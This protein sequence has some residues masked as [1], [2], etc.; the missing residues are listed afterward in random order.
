[1]KKYLL[2]FS[3]IILLILTFLSTPI[4]QDLMFPLFQDLM[5][6]FIFLPSFSILFYG[7]GL[8]LIQKSK[9]SMLTQLVYI[10]FIGT[11]FVYNLKNYSFHIKILAITIGFLIGY[12]FN[13]F[14]KSTLINKKS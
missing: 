13:N 12:I 5:T 7:I 2:A 3:S 14:F 6:F 11:I 8:Y 9:L 4:E 1:M 10:V